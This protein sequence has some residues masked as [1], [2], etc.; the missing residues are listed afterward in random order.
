[1][2]Y[3]GRTWDI[4]VSLSADPGR[5]VIIP[6]TATALGGASPAD[7]SGVP[8]TVTFSTQEECFDSDGEIIEDGI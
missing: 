2:V 1:M 3:E 7:Y 5:E 8:Q 6:V 4:G